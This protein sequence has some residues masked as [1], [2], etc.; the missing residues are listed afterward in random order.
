MSTKKFQTE[1]YTLP[2]YWLPVLVNGDPGDLTYEE[3]AEVERFSAD[4]PCAMLDNIS[5]PF[6]ATW[7]S[8]KRYGMNLACTCVEVDVTW[9][10]DLTTN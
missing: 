6:F 8:G 3:L 7:H 1:R 9:P 5:E 2:E 4:H 10:A